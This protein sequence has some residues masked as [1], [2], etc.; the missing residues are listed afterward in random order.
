MELHNHFARPEQH[1]VLRTADYP[2]SFA[3]HTGTLTGKSAQLVVEAG[4]SALT[5]AVHSPESG[6]MS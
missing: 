1:D 2:Q 6:V 3:E 5:P 4:R